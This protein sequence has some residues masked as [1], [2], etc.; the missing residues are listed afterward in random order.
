MS[1]NK[2][3]YETFISSDEFKKDIEEN[4]KEESKEQVHNFLKLLFNRVEE[5][6]IKP[7]QESKDNNKL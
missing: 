1:E 3:L 5:V 7:L 2:S 4:T 6:Y